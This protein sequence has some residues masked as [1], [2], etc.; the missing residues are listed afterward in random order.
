MAAAPRHLQ[1]RALAASVAAITDPIPGY[2][3]FRVYVDN[4]AEPDAPP[5]ADVWIRGCYPIQAESILSAVWNATAGGGAGRG[6]RARLIS[7]SGV[8]STIDDGPH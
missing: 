4:R 8:V 6:Y 1:P 2:P 3:V 7:A 5:L